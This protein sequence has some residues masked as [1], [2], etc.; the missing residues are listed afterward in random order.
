MTF[1]EFRIKIFTFL[2][3]VKVPMN[4]LKINNK[5]NKG[6]RQYLNMMTFI[7]K[8]YHWFLPLSLEGFLGTPLLI[9][10]QHC[11]GVRCLISS[12]V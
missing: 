1:L 8:V 5:K 12:L 7:I 9:I 10:F 4:K 3:V 2:F 11:S 6:G